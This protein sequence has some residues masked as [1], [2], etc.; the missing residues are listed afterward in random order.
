MIAIKRENTFSAGINGAFFILDAVSVGA[1][2]TLQ[3][4]VKPVAK[5][6]VPVLGMSGR[7]MAN[8]A[9]RHQAAVWEDVTIHCAKYWA[10]KAAAKTTAAIV[11][12][13]AVKLAVVTGTKAV[14]SDPSSA[15]KP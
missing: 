9:V 10:K 5:V 8:W 12:G 13:Q 4:A 14:S 15:A 7:E 11:G 3:G 6:A 2:S 1:Y